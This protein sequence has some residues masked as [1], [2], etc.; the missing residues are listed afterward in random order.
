MNI[1]SL[2]SIAISLIQQ[3]DFVIE[4]DCILIGKNINLIAKSKANE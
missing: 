2:S 4:S 1:K 3:P